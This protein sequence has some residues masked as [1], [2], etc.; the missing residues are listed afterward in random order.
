LKKHLSITFFVLMIAFS[1]VACKS[2]QEEAALVPDNVSQE[3]IPGLIADKTLEQF[4]STLVIP[5]DALIGA[6]KVEPR[7]VSIQE[8][9]RFS[10]WAIDPTEVNKTNTNYGVVKGVLIVCDGKPL[11][12]LTPLSVYRSDI[13]KQFSLTE[14]ELAGFDVKIPANLF[15]KGTHTLQLY[16]ILKN[17]KYSRLQDPSSSTDKYKIIINVT[18]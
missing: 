2:E 13:T 14:K 6:V 7:S 9:L 8:N 10:G 5:T 17:G 4:D 12:Y 18:D 3:K 15:T 11:P 1:L 16:G